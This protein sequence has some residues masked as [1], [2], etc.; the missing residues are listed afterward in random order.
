VGAAVVGHDREAVP[1]EPGDEAFG[2]ATVV[3]DAVQ[4]DERATERTLWFTPPAAQR[5]TSAFEFALAASVRRSLRMDDASR[6]Q[7]RARNHGR[8]LA[9]EQRAQ[10]ERGDEH[11]QADLGFQVWDFEFR[12]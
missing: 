6:P 10:E 7:N 12:I 11:D 4:R 8:C 9:Q 1:A 3:R 2:P 5:D